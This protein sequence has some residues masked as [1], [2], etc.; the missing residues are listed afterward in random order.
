MAALAVLLSLSTHAHDVEVNGIYYNLN[1]TNKTATVTYKGTDYDSRAYS[2]SVVIPASIVNGGITYTVISIGEQ[3]FW[4]CSGLTS[5]SI[6]N[7]VTSIGRYAFSFCSRLT[8]VTIPNSVTSIGLEAFSGCS[9]LTAIT[10]ASDNPKYDSRNNCNA[11]IETSS[12]I[13]LAGCKNTTIPNNVTSIGE[14]VFLGCSGLTA[15]TIPSSVTSIGWSAF[16]GCSSLTAVDIPNSVTRIDPHAFRECSGL[17]TVSIPNSVTSISECTFIECS[18]LTSVTIPNSVTYIGS[19][20]FYGT[21]WY[22]NQPDG[23][24]YAG[25]VAYKYKGTMSDNTSIIIREG[26][27]CISGLAFNGCSGLAAVDIPNS[28][29]SIDYMAFS[30]CSGLTA[31]NIPN[32]VTSIDYMA[33]Y[34]CSGLT[35]V[36]IPNSVTSIGMYAFQNCS[37]LTTMNI[38]NSVTSIGGY[39]F[40]GCSGL[41]TVSIPNSVTSI[42]SSAFYNCSGLKDVYCYTKEV[43]NRN[44][45]AFDQSY[46]GNATLHVPAESVDSY[47]ATYPWNKF[48]MIVPIK[49]KCATPTISFA[50]GKVKV[51]CATEGAKCVTRIVTE[52]QA[53]EDAEID[54]SSEFTVRTYATAEGYDDSEVVTATFNR[55]QTTGDLDGDGYVN[56]SDVTTLVNIIL[57]K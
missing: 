28:V 57:E 52:E 20:A 38:P 5:V 54:L 12:N 51:T 43:P 34:G 18:S 46:I 23:L 31:V 35:D 24:I 29:T 33:F 36:S 1:S 9:G 22:N 40:Y 7:S 15:V 48:G 44:G 14:G 49:E 39:A 30:G 45:Y 47:K 27:T 56:I 41:T 53:S 4:Q 16:S 55:S 37:S 13:L 21:P 50:N 19:N 17:T 2:S 25:R 10:V 32:S 3:A 8:D 6:P 42:G 26:T 11:I